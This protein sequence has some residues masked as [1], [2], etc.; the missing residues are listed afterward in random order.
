MMNNK[1][2]SLATNTIMLGI[3]T[4]CSKCLSFLFVPL[5]SRWLTT[6]QYGD[7]DLYVTY[8]TLLVP[9][10]TLST[11]EALFRFL[12]DESDEK[13]RKSVVTNSALVSGL[14]SI[15]VSIVVFLFL[16]MQSKELAIP[17]V[18]YLISEVIYG[19]ITYF[20]RGIR[21]LN[22]YAFTGTIN[23]LVTFCAVFFLVKI[24]G[25]GTA[26]MMLGYAVAFSITSVIIILKTKIW[27]FLEIKLID[28]AVMKELIVYSL[29]MIP[30]AISWWIVN[31]SDRSIIKIFLG[32]A[33]NGLYALANKIPALCTTLFNVFHLSWQENISLTIDDN[34]RNTYI[35]EVFNQIAQTMI[36]ICLPV[37]S[38]NYF[39]FRYVF[40]ADYFDGTYQVPILMASVIVNVMAQFFGG[41]FVALKQPKMN[42]STTVIGAATNI[43]V[44]L[45]SIRFIGLYAASLS[46]LIAFIV[47]FVIR[48]IILAKKFNI[49]VIF[50]IKTVVILGI[51]LLYVFLDL[52]HS[53][54][55][56]VVLFVVG[57][58]VFLYVN[59]KFAVA[60][61][62]KVW[63]R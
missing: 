10:M 36:S 63:R 62:A 44:H 51:Y 60:L 15:V 34:D 56:S 22:I 54:I 20:L 13:H 37:L 58:I 53:A 21:K 50:E 38:V 31:V 41:I 45:V 12:V 11:G 49:K 27:K 16:K 57:C 32:S 52:Q 9:F 23:M 55:I 30:N 35:N 24:E 7:F 59:R 43:V 25:Y 48:Y 17:F 4:I 19:F 8:V 6:S 28:P 39:L 3:G 33:F 2:K 1:K 42:G 46:T 40:S 5:F 61:L 29:P 14:G 18:I 47:L 26:G